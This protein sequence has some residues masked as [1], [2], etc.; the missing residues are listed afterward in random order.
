MNEKLKREF[1]YPADEFSPMPFWFWNDMLDEEEI[2]RQIY[3]MHEKGVC[4]FVLHP[5]IGI[6]KDIPYLSDRFLSYVQCAVREAQKLGMR[7]ILYDEG[8]YPSGSA[9][10]MVVERNAEFASKG[11]RVEESMRAQVMLGKN[12]RLISTLVAEKKDNLTLKNIKK[13]SECDQKLPENGVYLHL[14]QGFTGGHIRGIHIGE[15]DWENPPKSADLLNP[16]A[17]DTF[18]ELTHQRYYRAL[19]DYFGNTVVAVFT[20]EPCIMGREGDPRMKPWTDDFLPDFL[21]EGCRMED[22]PALWYSVGETT[23]NIRKKYAQ[24]VEK[25]LIRTFYKRIYDWCEEHGVKL[26]GHPAESEDIGLLQQFH[27]PGQDLIFRRVAPEDGKALWGAESTQAK[28]SADAAR[29]HGQRRNLNEC[30]ACSGKNGIEW[31][32]T[33]DDMK[34]MMDWLF[35]RGVNMLVPHAFFYSVRGER[36]YGERPP[37]VG[38]NNIWWKHY[39]W[40]SAYIKRMC[41]LMT[42]S[43]N[44]AE[45]AILCE[46]DSLPYVVAKTLYENQIEFNY[47]E[48]SLIDSGACTVKDGTLCIGRQ[49]YKTLI[50]EKGRNISEKVKE[51]SGQGIRVVVYQP[52]QVEMPREI[53]AINAPED[54][55]PYLNKDIEMEP[56]NHDLRMSH[57]IKEG[58]HFYVIVNEGEKEITGTLTLRTDGDI[59]VLDAW[60]GTAKPYVGQSLRIRRRESLIFAVGKNLHTQKKICLGETDAYEMEIPLRS[61]SVNGKEMPLGSWNDRPEMRN[62]CGTLI[63]ETEFEMPLGNWKNVVLDLGRVGENAEVTINGNPADFRLW[64]PYEFRLTPWIQVGKNKLSVAVTNSMAN[65]YTQQRT[66]S[67]ILEQPVLKIK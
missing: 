34:W 62:F 5:R 26:A 29:H 9:H 43:I 36:R 38:P 64:A 51:F 10:G 23:E 63:Y 21:A 41:Y 33:A 18:I 1:T 66:E 7:V 20:D 65:R 54:V 60:E 4:G 32:F 3:D 52:G 67:G 56:A 44:T 40:I 14:I 17:T 39:A 55:V 27:I 31:S 47:L 53:I 15:D 2:K 35:I 25:R 37:D 24:A 11:I 12:E 61:W 30:F 16:E 22:L 50:C 6:P 48:E 13:Y 42:D 8:M 59:F 46:S 19:A 28:C 49:C 45:T 58:E 57:I